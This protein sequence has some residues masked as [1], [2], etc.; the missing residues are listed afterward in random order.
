MSLESRRRLIRRLDVIFLVGLLVTSGLA[1]LLFWT[2][3]YDGD[4]DEDVMVEAISGTGT[5][6]PTVSVT[7]T[8]V[9]TATPSE[10]MTPTLT[11]TPTETVSPEPSPAKPSPQVAPLALA[12]TYAGEPFLITGESDPGDTIEVYDNDSLIALSQANAAG[13]WIVE[14]PSGLDEGSH[15]LAVVAIGSDGT[16]SALVPI[17]FDVLA[18]PTG[19]P[20]PPTETPL[21]TDTATIAP[22][23][24]PLPTDTATIVPTET[25]LPTAT[26]TEQAV[27][28]VSTETPTAAPTETATATPTETAVPT[29]TP[30]ETATATATNTLTYTPTATPSATATST[31][32]PIPPQI[33]AP[34]A[35]AV[36][37][38]GPVTVSG[39]AAPGA[40]IT[41]QADG[42]NVAEAVAATDGVWQTTVDLGGEGDVSLVV[43]A[44]GDDP[45]VSEAVTVVLAPPLHSITGAERPGAEPAETGRAFTALLALLL[46]AG[47][48][49]TFFA[50]RLVIMLARER[51]RR[52][53]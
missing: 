32:T 10:T 1:A 7:V 6:T 12:G 13:V 26:A 29:E 52:T 47:G 50:G 2:Q 22:T 31:T 30:T 41:V 24:T 35:G 42:V 21:P 25:P 3:F 44:A 33:D 20:V 15:S 23:E 9:P 43:S 38:P 46:T 14:M 17:G 36:F 51:L 18:A 37:A 4:D 48:F 45:L 11:A 49:S 8:D 28:Q 27:A 39:S 5:P 19:T 16:T 40:A 34:E 53:D